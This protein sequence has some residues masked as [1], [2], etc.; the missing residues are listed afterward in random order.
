MSNIGENNK[1]ED[2]IGEN[3]KRED[4]KVEDN[5]NDNNDDESLTKNGRNGTAV[6]NPKQGI[7]NETVT[8]TPSSSEK[9]DTKTPVTQVPAVKNAT[10]PTAKTD[11]GI[12][13]K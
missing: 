11:V 10:E 8:K 3:N 1:E 2:N 12:V 4:N 6:E 5:K 13:T 9:Q 7:V